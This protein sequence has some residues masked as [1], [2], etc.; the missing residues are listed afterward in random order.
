[1]AANEYK[2]R[3]RQYY[4]PEC[5]ASFEGPGSSQFG[6][7]HGASAHQRLVQIQTRPGSIK[8]GNSHAQDPQKPPQEPDGPWWRRMMQKV[9]PS[10]KVYGRKRNKKRW[11]E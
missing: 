10:G 8:T 6:Y 9:K 5:G 1:M 3:F 11:E 4:C 2:G 7:R